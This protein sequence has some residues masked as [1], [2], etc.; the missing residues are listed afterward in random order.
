VP[1]NLAAN[2]DVNA[3]LSVT[4]SEA[5][6]QSDFNV[7]LAPVV[8]LGEPVWSNGGKTVTFDPPAPLT[9]DTQYTFTIFPDGV[10]DLAGNGIVGVHTVQFT[11]AA[12]LAGGSIAGTVAGDPGTPA[13]NPS[14][15]TVVAVDSS[16]FNGEPFNVFGSTKVAANYN[17]SVLYLVDG[18]Y[19]IVGAKDTNGDGNLDPFTGDAVGGFGV[20]IDN[21]D[22]VPDSIAVAGGAH[23]TGKNFALFD[24]STASGTVQYTGS[25]TG[26]HA[27][28]VGLFDTTGFSTDDEPIAGTEALG[29]D[30]EWLINSFESGFTGDD[31][32]VGAYMDVNDSGFFEPLTDPAGFY[33]GLPA[34]TAVHVSNG[35][36]VTGIVVHI[37]DPTPGITAPASIIWPKAK[38]NA[39]FQRLV[40]IVR[41]SQQQVS[42]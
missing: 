39:V 40:D 37:T 24:P 38:H 28:R 1:A 29:I 34:P 5:I 31:F 16:P 9:D 35:T 32:Y 10:F 33:G 14:G 27:I 15:T 18:T 11:T 23:V 20:D 12:T 26:E 4:F 6:N 42:R 21:A 41:Q 25:A 3:N 13:A 2:V 22:L 17:Y 7:D 19:S 36:D 8:T 30:H